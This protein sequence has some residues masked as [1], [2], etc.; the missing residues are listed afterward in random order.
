MNWGWSWA[1]VHIR[2]AVQA[3]LFR[4]DNRGHFT[5]DAGITRAE[6]VVVLARVLRMPTV[7]VTTL[8]P[9]RRSF[10]PADPARIAAEPETGALLVTGEVVV[11]ATPGT[12]A[13]VVA[14][15]AERVGGRVVGSHPALGLY[16]I[17]IAAE[18][19]AGVEEAVGRLTGLPGVEWAVRNIVIGGNVRC[20]RDTYWLRRDD[21]EAAPCRPA[22]DAR[23]WGPLMLKLPQAW[24]LRTGDS[25]TVG[26]IEGDFPAYH[27]DLAGLQ[28]VRLRAD[29]PD[30]GEAD[31]GAHVACIIGARGENNEGMAGVLWR[32][33]LIG[34]STATFLDIAEALEALSEHARVINMSLGVGW[35]DPLLLAGLALGPGPPHA[36]VV[37]EAN[38]TIR[39]AM[40]RALS[41]GVLVVVSAGNYGWPT[42]FASPASLSAVFPNVI[43]VG[44][45]DVQGN[46]MRVLALGGRDLAAS[47]YGPEVTI[48]A[49]G[50]NI[51]SCVD[52]AGPGR[53][54]RSDAWYDY[55][56]G[57]SMAARFVAGVAALIWSADPDL[58]YAEVKSILVRTAAPASFD[59]PLGAG[60]V[61][62]EAAVAATALGLIQKAQREMDLAETREGTARR[63]HLVRAIRELDKAL[64]LNWEPAAKAVAHVLRAKARYELEDFAAAIDDCDKAL[65]LN[66]NLAPA[67]HIR[68]AARFAVPG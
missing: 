18:G 20:P 10:R 58:T 61:N 19:V 24:G 52:P 48:A 28:H 49:P 66:P 37:R 8:T 60:I 41:R 64:R 50:V 57:T 27:P 59:R 54:N 3:G 17:E 6:A 2:R 36:R 4:G 15:A 11:V 26:I 14:A 23:L 38:E 44:A 68:A 47:N 40:Q 43:T 31:H 67:Y 35:S 12:S 1:T 33:N 9:E 45:V 53:K 25:V 16:Q 65:V 56:T 22:G 62:A 55:M 21:G 42:A 51:F 32:P 7:A 30:T 13:A 63:A 39:S 34:Y 46:R 5:P 29:T